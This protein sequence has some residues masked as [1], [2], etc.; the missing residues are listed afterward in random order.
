[1]IASLGSFGTV[2]SA[3]F[4]VARAWAV[5]ADVRFEAKC[6]GD[7]GFDEGRRG[8]ACFDARY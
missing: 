5:M 1:V 8:Q 6:G 7:E 4:G 2:P 3:I